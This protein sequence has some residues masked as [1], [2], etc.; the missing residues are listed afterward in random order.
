MIISILRFIIVIFIFLTIA[1][2]VLI[3]GWAPKYVTIH[4]LKMHYNKLTINRFIEKQQTKTYIVTGA[5]SGTG[6]VSVK[7]FAQYKGST[8]I[9]TARTLKKA[10]NAKNDIIN[11][12]INESN[13]FTKDDLNKR[14]ITKE[15]ELSSFD[16]VK[17]FCNDLNK[18]KQRIDVLL[19]NAGVMKNFDLGTK[20]GYE[21][22]N[23]GYEIHVQV[24]YLSQFLT[25][26][27]LNN[28]IIENSKDHEVR[29]LSVSSGAYANAPK[30]YNY[31]GVDTDYA[32]KPKSKDQMIEYYEDGKWYGMSKLMEIFFAKELQEKYNKQNLNIKVFSLQ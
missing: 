11:E 2:S 8:V 20:F 12:I 28:L 21:I 3:G 15:L 18:S 14:I 7:E 29:I 19:L 30:E 24:N 32:W 4:G 27:L 25:M 10:E 1:L 22:T 6:Y 31:I 17:K 9:M 5:T 13:E 16:S 23:D 26:K